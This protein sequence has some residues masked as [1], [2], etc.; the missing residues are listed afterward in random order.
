[1]KSVKSKIIVYAPVVKL[2][3]RDLINV[4]IFNELERCFDVVWAFQEKY[5]SGYLKSDAVIQ[6]LNVSKLRKFI[7]SFLFELSN[8]RY[9]KKIIGAK[10]SFPFLGMARKQIFILKLINCLRVTGIMIYCLRLFLRLTAPHPPNSFKGS[11]CV[12]CFASSKDP[13]F[14]DIVRMAKEDNIKV[15]LVCLN[16][17]NASSKPYIEKPDLVLTWG[18]QTAVLSSYLHKIT[19]KPIGAP[20][21]ESYKAHKAIDFIIAQSKL[22]LTIGKQYIIFAGVGFPFPEIEILNLLCEYLEKNQLT[23]YCIIYR[24]HPYSWKRKNVEK[25]SLFNTYVI[26]DPTLSMF[27]ENDLSQYKYLFASCK[28]LITCYSTMVVEA[29]IHGMPVL[30]IAF[31]H[32]ESDKYDWINNANVAPHLGILRDSDWIQKCHDINK[33]QSVFLELLQNIGD[34]K[35]SNAA[36]QTGRRIV[37][38]SSESYSNLISNEINSLINK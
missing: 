38:M 36:I 5:P 24:P 4:N 32:A 10:Q 8:Y 28:A 33:L 14:D 6:L 22:G 30:L 15:I 12:I 16:W 3:F 31:P 19:S 23:N 13:V 35:I 21:F 37:H 34:K 27:D 1:M 18:H 9:N 29:A 17:D 20:R 2:G 7:W 25:N 11:R 26:L